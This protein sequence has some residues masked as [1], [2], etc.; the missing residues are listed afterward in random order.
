MLDKLKSLHLQILSGGII[1]I[2]A[3]TILFPKLPFIFVPKT[4]VAVR[5]EDFVI[6]F[7]V[8]LSLPIL[9]KRRKEL[10][11]DNLVLAI[12]GF[13]LIGLFS[14]FSAIFVTQTV[15]PHLAVL[16]YLRRIEYIAPLFLVL[17]VSP[18]LGKITDYFK[19]LV[20]ISIVVFIYGLGQMYFDFP[21]FSTSNSEFAKGI[22]LT[23][24]PEAR[25]NSTFAGH[26]DL[27][28]YLAVSLSIFGALAFGTS[29]MVK[30]RT[31][32][33]VLLLVALSNLWLLL[34]TASRISFV[35]YLLGITVVML[36]LKKRVLLILILIFSTLSLLSSDEIRVRFFNTLK[37]GTKT[38]SQEILPQ[39]FAQTATES[40]NNVTQSVSSLAT[41]KLYEDVVEGEPTDTQKLGVFRSSRVRFDREWPDAKRAFLRNP[42]LGSGYS[43]LG[44]ATDN[45]YLRSLGEVGILGTFSFGLIFVEITKRII[46]FLKKT[47]QTNFQKTIVIGFSG[48]IVAIL[49]NA[50]FI[51]VF[52]ASKVAI[53]FWM[54]VGVLASTMKLSD[55]SSEDN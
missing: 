35:S 49:V 54:F 39:T 43:S 14:T 25:V 11:Q 46:S 30:G 19:L 41:T 13:F 8:L 44:L 26:Y 7:F 24:G 21:V 37:Y 42:L 5:L 40:A 10:L 12:L 3:V 20:F 23:L 50:T 17:A 31:A 6:L 38:L 34:Q 9:F 16:H 45:D 18:N 4:F 15:T 27:A 36:L 2:L 51:D 32:K 47:S 22:P 29:F 53:L 28:A 48:M 33:I 55:E 52:E 1:A